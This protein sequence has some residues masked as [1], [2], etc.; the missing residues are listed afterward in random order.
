MFFFFIISWK[1]TFYVSNT[2]KKSVHQKS[3]MK[4]FTKSIKLIEKMSFCYCRIVSLFLFLHMNY[5]WLVF[6]KGCHAPCSIDTGNDLCAKMTLKRRKINMTIYE[7]S[8]I[9]LCDLEKLKK[10]TFSGRS[11][12]SNICISN[13]LFVF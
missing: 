2:M 9:A 1:Y 5:F 8:P 3:I 11:L 4:S 7:I 12:V 10:K 6:V 13:A